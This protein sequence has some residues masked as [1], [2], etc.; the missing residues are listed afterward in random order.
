M[1]HKLTSNLCTDLSG[2][3][4][5]TPLVYVVKLQFFFYT[6]SLFLSL[7]LCLVDKIVAE[8]K[9]SLDIMMCDEEEFDCCNDL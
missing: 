8:N 4:R 3:Q 2:V 1:K 9:Y 7:Q 6:V 5:D